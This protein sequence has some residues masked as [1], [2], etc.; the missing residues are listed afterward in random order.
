MAQQLTASTALAEDRTVDSQPLTVA[1][2]PIPAPRGP[3]ALFDFCG[4]YTHVLPI[5]HSVCVQT[6]THRI[7]IF[8]KFC[9]GAEDMAQQLRALPVFAEE[10]G[11][12]SSVP[13]AF[14]N[15]LKPQSERVQHPTDTK[16]T[17]GSDLHASK[18]SIYIKYF[19][20]K[21]LSKR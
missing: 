21:I 7:N 19:F 20:I 8:K 12:I 4:L 14:N 5:I 15:C 3:E 11:S 6:H 2:S 9:Q 13:K 18:T 10:L 16:H 17:C 1:L